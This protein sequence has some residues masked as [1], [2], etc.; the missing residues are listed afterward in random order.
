MLRA[1]SSLSHR[2]THG[3]PTDL[4]L[5]EKLT[6]RQHDGLCRQP[7]S[8][9]AGRW[10]RRG[11]AG[12][13]K[14]DA[15]PPKPPR[16][17]RWRCYATPKCPQS[18]RDEGYTFWAHDAPSTLQPHLGAPGRR[19][20]VEMLIVMLGAPARVPR[21]TSRP[22]AASADA[23]WTAWIDGTICLRGGEA[24]IIELRSELAGISPNMMRF[25]SRTFRSRG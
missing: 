22:S 23:R 12:R 17:A 3:F 6:A 14:H 8:A 16:Y 25:P 21:G 11:E 1:P 13:G 10:I 9:R 7:S 2:A 5:Q 19:Q 24:A 15:A 20:A 4:Y 18:L